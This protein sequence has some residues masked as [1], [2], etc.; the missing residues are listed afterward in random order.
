MKLADKIKT[1]VE[2]GLIQPDQGKAIEQF[3]ANRHS[4]PYAMYS[5]VILGV[6][7]I[8]IGII[9]LIAANWEDIPDAVKLGTDILILLITAFF[10]FY[11]R[12]SPILYY[13]LSVFF[14]IFVLASIGLISQVF[15]TGGELYEAVALALLL[16]APLM[17]LQEGR[18]L[19]HLW[20][21][22]FVFALLNYLFDQY[23]FHSFGLGAV[24][25]LTTGSIL[26][27]AGLVLRSAGAVLQTQARASFAWGV[28]VLSIA[29]IYFS[30]ADLESS[31][32]KDSSIETWVL[33]PSILLV[34]AA[35]YSF[36]ML[37]RTLPRRI[38]VLAAFGFLYVLVFFSLFVYPVGDKF[39]YLG[40]LFVILAMCAAIAFFDYRYLFDTFLVIAGIRFLVI[41]FELFEDLATTGI[42]LI[43]AGLIIIGGVI[44]YAKSRSRIQEYLKERLK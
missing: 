35:A 16:T 34:C 24:H 28:L 43:L 29:A 26:L 5:F 33:I 17:F 9:S 42:G 27:L 30:F 40:I 13:S 44:L 18:F 15:H 22:G 23:Y 4:R 39:T 2:A 3:E 19:A 20:I 32:L 38:M 8:S 25:I 1:W 10:V 11:Y 37:P 31:D 14:S 12:K 6:T 21:A 41:Y 7:V 36:F